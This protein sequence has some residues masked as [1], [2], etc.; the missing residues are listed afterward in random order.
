MLVKISTRSW[1]WK[2]YIYIYVSK[3]VVL[4]ILDDLLLGLL[5][6]DKFRFRSLF[7]SW[8]DDGWTNIIFGVIV[9]KVG[10]LK[11]LVNI[12]DILDVKSVPFD[13]SQKNQYFG[14][15]IGL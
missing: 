7:S 1:R 10:W 4:N 2:H 6:I 11:D 14:D 3:L 8:D 12:V 9:E 13:P 15:Y 5:N